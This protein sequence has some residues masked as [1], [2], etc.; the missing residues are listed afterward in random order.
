QSLVQQPVVTANQIQPD[1][2]FPSGTETILVAEDNDTVRILTRN[3]LQENGYRVIE[4]RHGDDALQ[5]FMENADEIRLLLLDVLMPKKNGWGVYEM[6]CKIRPGIKV[7][8]MSGYTAD[9]FDKRL[10]PEQG[11]PLMGKPIP[12]GDLLRAL[13]RELDPIGQDH[14]C[15]QNPEERIFMHTA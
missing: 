3:L 14:R 12:P 8:F 11:V 10:I 1:E 13:R 6:I 9:V 15:G 4:A 7:I 5:R 2:G